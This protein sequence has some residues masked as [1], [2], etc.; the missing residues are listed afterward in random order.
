M[1]PV[2]MQFPMQLLVMQLL[3]HGH[4]VH[5]PSGAD[6]KMSYCG[7]AADRGWHL[8]LSER[9]TFLEHVT[10]D[11]CKHRMSMAAM[12]TAVTTAVMTARV[13]QG[14]YLNR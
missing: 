5:I 6:A 13:A 3:V 10:C 4:E 12:R 11:A 1:Q 2:P 14:G 9:D 8:E 7:V